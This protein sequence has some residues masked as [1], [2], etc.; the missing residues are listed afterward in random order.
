MPKIY[1]VEGNIGSGKSTIIK[2]LKKE[3]RFTKYRKILYLQEPVDVWETFSD[4]ENNIIEKFYENQKEWAFSFQ[5]MAFISRIAQLKRKIQKYNYN[6]YIII[7]E[8]CVETDKNVFAKMLFDEEKINPINYQIYLKW[9]DEFVS[10]IKIDGHVYLK[11]E[12]EISLERIK[13]RNRKGETI[14]LNYL[15]KCHDYHNNWL[16]EKDNVFIIDVSSEISEELANKWGNSIINYIADDI[17]E[18]NK[19]KY[20]EVNTIMDNH[21]C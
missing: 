7:T 17:T 18:Y 21:I 15:K 1:S 12:P 2:N 5:M 10:D 20:K 11:T 4:G 13:K 6:S 3:F 8:R 19:K 16:N 14:S 9:F